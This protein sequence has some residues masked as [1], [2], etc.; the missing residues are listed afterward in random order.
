[1]YMQIS[2]LTQYGKASTCLQPDG[3]PIDLLGREILRVSDLKRSRFSV[4]TSSKIWSE[5]Q[6]PHVAEAMVELGQEDAV[7]HQPV[8]QHRLRELKQHEKECKRKKQRKQ[9]AR[10]AGDQLQEDAGPTHSKTS[11]GRTGRLLSRAARPSSRSARLCSRTGF[12]LLSSDGPMVPPVDE[13]SL[14]QMTIKQEHEDVNA[15]ALGTITERGL[16]RAARKAERRERITR[17]DAER[18]ERV[19]R[20]RMEWDRMEK[21]RKKAAI[22]AEL[23]ALMAKKAELEE[24]PMEPKTEPVEETAMSA[25]FLTSTW[26]DNVWCRMTRS[27]R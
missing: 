22:E 25:T 27:Q 17:E 2:K 10:T 23:Q 4:L 19:E 8:S 1:M 6:G 16:E 14:I 20:D 24:A 7:V 18:V 26:K 21:E 9:A 13:S 5:V 11:T 15:A 3:M 12:A